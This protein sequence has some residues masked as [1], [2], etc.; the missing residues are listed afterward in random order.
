MTQKAR[1]QENYQE[2]NYVCSVRRDQN[3]KL[4]TVKGRR[5]CPAS[6]V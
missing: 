2:L 5:F 1:A 4:H 3:M 6:T